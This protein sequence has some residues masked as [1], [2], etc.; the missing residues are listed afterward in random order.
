MAGQEY[1]IEVKNKFTAELEKFQKETEQ[2]K[3]AMAGFKAELS[4]I[5]QATSGIKKASSALK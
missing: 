3:Q 5:G 4:S 2:A 1:T